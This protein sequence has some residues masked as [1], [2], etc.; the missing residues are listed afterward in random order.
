MPQAG[1]AFEFSNLISPPSRAALVPP[2]LRF[3]WS[4]CRGLKLALPQAPPTKT[5][6]GLHPIHIKPSLRRRI[7]SET[8]HHVGMTLPGRLSRMVLM[9]LGRE[10]LPMSELEL[11]DG[12]PGE[13]GTMSWADCATW[14]AETQ[15]ASD[16]HKLTRAPDLDREARAWDHPARVVFLCR[17]EGRAS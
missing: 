6:T 12:Q 15:P 7:P 16:G 14:D 10:S 9:A 17:R 3:H 8:R 4:F 11:C 13:G 5:T 1:N 2:N